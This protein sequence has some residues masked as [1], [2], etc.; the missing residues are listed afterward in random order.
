MQR[1]ARPI[2][3]ISSR[4]GRSASARGTSTRTA[5]GVSSPTAASAPSLR[6]LTAAP[7]NAT[8]SAIAFGQLEYVLDLA[9]KREK[10]LP[11][12]AGIKSAEEM[13]SRPKL[14]RHIA[15]IR[16]VRVMDQNSEAPTE[17]ALSQVLNV[18]ERRNAVIHA[19]WAWHDGALRY[20][21]PRSDTWRPAD[22]REL[23][24]LR[25]D[26]EVVR[27]NLNRIAER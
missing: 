9:F 13:I 22:K 15:S 26:I 12:L 19:C 3:P 20:K 27:D 4:M 11:L 21:S 23:I 16:A 17:H 1:M 6:A 14:C 24:A 5:D 10:S 8:S 25:Q 2:T 18:N 7:S